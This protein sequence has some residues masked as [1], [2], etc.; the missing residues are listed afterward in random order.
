MLFSCLLEV[1]LEGFQYPV[2][3][4]PGGCAQRAWQA[5]WGPLLRRVTALSSARPPRRAF[6][7]P[8]YTADMKATVT[9]LR[10]KGMRLRPTELDPA[11]EAELSLYDWP[12]ANSFGRPVRC[13]EVKV[14]VGSLMQAKAVLFDP[15]LIAVVDGH[16]CFAASSSTPSTAGCTSTSRSGAWPLRH[17]ARPSLTPPHTHELHARNACAPYVRA[18]AVTEFRGG[19]GES[20]TF[21]TTKAKRAAKPVFMRVPAFSITLTFP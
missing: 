2:H 14:P 17:S 16:P 5:H 15:E 21:L 8:S 9:L 20:L 7:C 12:T 11:I 13:M 4:P 6:S 18:R 10:R 19:F 3:H 1:L